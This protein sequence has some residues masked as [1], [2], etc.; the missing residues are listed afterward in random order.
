MTALIIAIIALII[1]I[2][3]AIKVTIDTIPWGKSEI[4]DSL[5]YK[6]DE[7]RNKRIDRYWSKH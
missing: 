5:T 6:R 1:S 7:R 3:T 4:I 2:A